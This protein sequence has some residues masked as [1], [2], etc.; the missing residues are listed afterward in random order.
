MAFR[1]GEREAPDHM[2]VMGLY[3]ADDLLNAFQSTGLYASFVITR[4]GQI[5][6]GTL[7]VVGTDLGLLKNVL[8]A[9]TKES[10]AETRAFGWSDISDLLFRRGDGRIGG[11][12]KGR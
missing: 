4:T 6:I 7:D 3:Q 2:V 5:S 10:T 8:K 1:L 12:L 9:D 11:R